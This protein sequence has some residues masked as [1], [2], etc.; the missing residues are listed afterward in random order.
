MKHMPFSILFRL[1][2]LTEAHVTAI[3]YLVVGN[4]V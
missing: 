1:H 4:G 2:S 3:A